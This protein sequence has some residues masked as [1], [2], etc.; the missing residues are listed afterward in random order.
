MTRLYL[1]VEGQTEETFVR[2]LMVPHYASLGLYITPIILTTRPGFRGGMSSY[3]K[4]KPQ[5]TRLC[6]QDRNAFVSTIVD[7]YALPDDFPGK[8]DSSYPTRNGGIQKAEFLEERLCIDIN[9]PNFVPHVMVHEFEALLFVG[10]EFFAEWA[11]SADTVDEIAA[12]AQEYPTP[13]DINDGPTTA[14]SKRILKAMPEYKKTLHGPLIIMDIGLDRC[15]A[16]CPHFD[17]WLRKLESLPKIA[18]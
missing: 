5:I 7:L 9:E 2:E 13:E 8:S 16:S 18:I 14:P 12:V 6:R 17:Q 3:A 11:S 15:R 10:P 4:V 1:L